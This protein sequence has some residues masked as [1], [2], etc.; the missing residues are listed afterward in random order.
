M[1]Y[2]GLIKNQYLFSTF[3]E[4]KKKCFLIKKA[5]TEWNYQQ[6]VIYRMYVFS[7][8]LLKEKQKEIIWQELNQYSYL[9]HNGGNEDESWS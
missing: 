3:S 7:R 4:Y 2:Y 8:P 5:Y 6:I 9:V 1:S